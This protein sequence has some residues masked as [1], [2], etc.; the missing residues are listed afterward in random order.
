[1][2][3]VDFY[4]L[5]DAGLVV[6][7]R[8]AA[9][10]AAKCQQARQPCDLLLASDLWPEMERLLWAAKAESFLPTGEQQPVRM[11]SRDTDLT[12]AW[13]INLTE[14]PLPLAGLTR[15][16]EVIEQQPQSLAIGRDKW[17]HYQQLGIRPNK[18][19]L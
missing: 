7:L 17:R 11:I 16:F 14:Q 15:V 18:H 9:V 13:C 3:Q 10:L 4:L 2:A 12:R 8:L 1:M 6:R 5:P 19:S